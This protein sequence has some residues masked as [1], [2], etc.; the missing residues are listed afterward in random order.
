MPAPYI[1]QNL[2]EWKVTKTY[3]PRGI[4][5]SQLPREVFLDDWTVVKKNATENFSC[6][7]NFRRSITL[8]TCNIIICINYILAIFFT[9][10][11]F[12]FLIITWTLCLTKER[13]NRNNEQINLKSKRKIKSK[14]LLKLW[15]TRHTRRIHQTQFPV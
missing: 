13:Q 3:S 14:V 12:S 6:C 2:G 8:N 7:Q 10:S 1:S 9:V 15:K 4:K 11:I 5:V